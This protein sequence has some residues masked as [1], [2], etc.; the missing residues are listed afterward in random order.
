MKRGGRLTTEWLDTEDVLAIP[1]DTPIPGYRNDTVNTLRLWSARATEEFDLRYFNEGDYLRAVEE[2]A[3]SE[4]ITKVL[5]PNDN[6]SAGR[7][8]RLKQ[9]YFFVAATLQDIIRRYKKHY[10]LYDDQ[11]GLR[12]FDRFVERTA[13]QLNDTHPALAIPE[14]MRILVDVEGLGW[15]EAWSITTGTFGYTNHTVMPE[16]L[17]RWPVDLLGRLLPRHLQIIFE[18]NHRFLELVRAAGRRRRALPPHVDHRGGR[19]EAR[20]HGPPRDRGQPLRQRRG[21]PP[22]RDPE[23]R[24]V[25]G[26]L[27]AVAGEIQQQDERHHPAPLA[28]EGEPPA[29]RAHHARRSARSG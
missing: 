14:L 5:Y 29:F 28:Q 13:I 15:D 11:K 25:P 6:V 8:L 7:E 9:E 4:N 23:A 17:E 19:G 10:L 3:E 21:R 2:K 12:P 18:I 16:A 1:Y 20:A 27:R 26:L 22:H 24:A